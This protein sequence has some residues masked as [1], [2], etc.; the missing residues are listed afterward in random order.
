MFKR[1]ILLALLNPCVVSAQDA[2]FDPLTLEFQ[3]GLNN[4]INPMAS[5]YDA[6]SLGLF[7]GAAG[8]RYMFNPK[9]GLR[10]QT[11]YD[12]F[13]NRSGTKEFATSYYRV[14]VEGVVNVGNI[15][16]FYDWTNRFGL[17][18]HTGAGYS[19]MKEKQSDVGFDQMAHAMVGL[20]PQLRLNDRWCISLDATSIAHIYQSRTYDFSSGNYKRG[21]DGYLFSLAVGVQYSFGSGTHAD[22]VVPVDLSD[23]LTEIDQRIASLQESQKDDDGDGVANYLDEEP[24]TAM[25]A[26]VNTKGQTH[27]PEPKDSDGD[28]VPDVSDDCPF[29]KGGMESGGCPDTD[30]DGIADKADECP[31]IAGTSSS[32]G[33]PDIAPETT[34]LLTQAAAVLK[35]RN[36]RYE[37]PV[38]ANK[39]LDELVAVLKAHPEY[40]LVIAAHT[41]AEGDNLKNL[42]LTQRRADAVKLYLIGKGISGDRLYAF[43]F[44]ETQPVADVTTTDGNARNERMELHIRF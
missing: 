7:H 10:L 15:F 5:E 30:L 3:F 29:A 33:C 6:Q 24:G 26:T 12:Q 19:S 31:L 22:W 9:F 2:I 44:G 42:V 40:K 39:S 11:A 13:N 34:V 14:S 21:V 38:E 1:L 16:H 25:G 28:A 37:L 35:F 18:L 43:G 8:V 41:G 27:I 20:T 23:K 32:K 17:L 4:P 36:G